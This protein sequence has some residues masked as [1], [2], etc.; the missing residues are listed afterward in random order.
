MAQNQVSNETQDVKKFF[1]GYA[2]DF[3][4]IYGHT[5]S[6]SGFD[7]LMD[8]MFRQSMRLRFE[9]TVKASENPAV[10]SVLDV[11]CGSGVYCVEFL[12]QGKNV[13]GLDLA[14]GMLAIAKQKTAA[15][16]NTGKIDFVLAD[17][18]DYTPS[19]KWD[20][21]CLMGFFDYI[22]EPV[23]LIKKLQ[24]DITKEL[25]MSFPKKMGFLTWQRKVRYNMRH[26]PLYFYSKNSL[27]E[28][29]DKAGLKGRYTIKD[30]GRDFFVKV[31][32]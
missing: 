32:L 20:A 16:Q 18:M 25:Y 28:I 15:F 3:D 31:V 24:K 4:S 10:H 1:H 11:G 2:A 21:A 14:D 23:P 22:K 30:L 9:E 19:Q 13:L 12:K 7:K 8:K 5:K 27:V 17:Y 26:C 6:R 29:L